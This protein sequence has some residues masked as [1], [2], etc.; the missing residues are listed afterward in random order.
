MTM[1][2]I[3]R[4]LFALA[5]SKLHIFALFFCLVISSCGLEEP[6]NSSDESDVIEFVARPLGYNN[7]MVETKSAANDFEKEIHNCFFLLFDNATGERINTPV[8]LVGSEVATLPTQLVKLDKV[9]ATSVTACFIANVPSDMVSNIIGLDRPESIADTEENNQKYLNSAVLSGI[10]YGT[11][12]NFGKPYIDLDGAT[13]SN[14]PVACIPML[15]TQSIT[16]S[17][18]NNIIQVPLKRLFAKVT[19]NIKMQLTEVGIGQIVPSTVNYELTQYRLYHLPTKV[20]LIGCRCVGTCTCESN[21]VTNPSA[22]YANATTYLGSTENLGLQTI[23]IND[24]DNNEDNNSDVVEGIEFSF[25]VPEYYLLPKTGA[26]QNQ[27]SKPQ[28]YDNTDKIKKYPIYVELVGE[29]N[30]SLI[31]NTHIQHKIYLGG[32]EID[33]FTLKRN[34]KYINQITIHGT[35]NNNVDYRVSTEIVNNPVAKEGKAANCYIIAQPGKYTIPAYKGAYNNLSQA[36]LCMEGKDLSEYDTR[37]EVLANVVEYNNI[38]S[39]TFSERP[40]YDSQT[41]TIS[42]TVNSMLT[43]NWVPNGSV[44]MA[45]QYRK[46]G[47]TTWT[48]EWSWHLWFVYNATG[49]EDGWGTIGYQ[50]M[51]DGANDMMDRNLGVHASA[52]TN[53]GAQVGFYYKY[54]E[55][56]PYLDPDGDGTFAKYGGGIL[57]DSN[58]QPV[59][60]TWSASKSPT[61][62][63]PPGYKVPHSSVWASSKQEYMDF[64]SSYFTYKERSVSW[65]GIDLEAINYPYAGRS[66]SSLKIETTAYINDK[67]SVSGTISETLK[68]GSGNYRNI[69]YTIDLKYKFSGL[70]GS[71]KILYFGY[72]NISDNMKITSYEYSLTGLSYKKYSEGDRL[73]SPDAVMTLAKSK[74]EDNLASYVNVY[75]I[76]SVD[77]S[78]GYQVRCVKE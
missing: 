67:N 32:N 14:N 15:G 4:F 29:L 53:A 66:T 74:I 27:K 63:C 1:K 22:F 33:D 43:N 71:D 40:A 31:D 76:K 25:Y 44:I 72:C 57:Y 73:F 68:P 8:N 70:Y 77:T 10:T 58:S 2:N 3:Y 18:A 17:S 46:K 75:L 64:G 54:G 20:S 59:T 12:N 34:T 69:S 28:N 39:I 52:L 36:T 51:P 78:N 38:T 19:M 41:N 16:L 55:H 56:A 50:S 65:D 5:P 45:L 6:Y 24:S 30:R 60:P 35:D 21:W 49:S 9:K 42:F 61:D 47:A 48:T 7:Q 37:V 62:P 13:G 26:I 23:N 11:G